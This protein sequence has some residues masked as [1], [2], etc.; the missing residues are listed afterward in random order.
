MEKL[1]A[2]ID[3]MNRFIKSLFLAAFATPVF[4]D[5]ERAGDF[6]YYVLSLSWTP[7]WCTLDGDQRNA[8][9]CDAG[10]GFGFSLHGLWPQYEQGWPS[11]CT[12]V[13]RDPSRR[14]TEEMAD[15]MGSGG[16]AWYEWKKHGRCSG[17]SSQEYFDAARQAYES[18][19]RPAVLRAVGQ[20]YHL[21]ATVVEDAFLE[22]NPT[23][24]TDQ[25][26]ITCKQGFIQE[27]R[28]CLTKDLAPRNCGADVVQD[29]RLQDAEFAPLR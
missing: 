29:C 5:G 2:Y 12:T 26:T 7:T 4:A 3:S 14:Q 16:L 20:I 21:P 25:I 17:L 15:I 8:P 24:S 11:Y 6:D 9:Q 22:A 27:A 10:T 23:F 28:L 13:E 18:V 19:N 1:S